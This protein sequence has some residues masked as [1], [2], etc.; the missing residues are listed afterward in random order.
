MFLENNYICFSKKLIINS[1]SNYKIIMA[2]FIN[3]FIKLYF[4]KYKNFDELFYNSVIYSKYYLNYKTKNCIYDDETMNII[5][6]VDCEIKK[7]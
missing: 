1:I 7:T 5:F 6:S 3:V 2:K 4:E